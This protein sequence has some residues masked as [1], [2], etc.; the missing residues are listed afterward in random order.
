M[1]RSFNDVLQW[2]TSLLSLPI[3]IYSMKLKKY[4]QLFIED[5]DVSDSLKVT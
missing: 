4:K 2:F 1:R 3:D 5:L